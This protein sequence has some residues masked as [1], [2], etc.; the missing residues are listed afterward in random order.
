LVFPE[1]GSEGAQRRQLRQICNRPRRTAQPGAWG[2]HELT[3]E[4]VQPSMNKP[5]GPY[6]KGPGAMLNG[7]R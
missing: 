1:H 6:M 3:V 4:D 2:V 7:G 5:G